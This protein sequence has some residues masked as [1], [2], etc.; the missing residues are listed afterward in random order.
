M[1]KS[2][3]AAQRE[4]IA[5]LLRKYPDHSHR[6]LARA[7]FKTWPEL[8]ISH[9][10]AYCAVR[11]FCGSRGNRS[12]KGRPLEK[13]RAESH[14]P[15]LPGSRAESWEP[16]QLDGAKRILILSDVHI[17]FHDT[18]ALKAALKFG[19]GFNPD[20]V[21]L[22]GD[23]A[24]FFSI[25]RYDSD[26][27]KRDLPGEI[28]AVRQF[29]SHVRARFPKARLVFKLGNHDERWLHFLWRKAPELLGLDVT[30][31]D[32]VIDAGKVGAEIVGDQRIIEVG[33]LSI[34]HGHEL[35]KGMTNPVNP[36]RGVFLRAIDIALIGHQHRTSEHTETTM[37]GRTITCWS[38]GCLCELHPEYAR[39]NRW[40]HGFA[41]VEVSR[42]QHFQVRNLRIRSGAIL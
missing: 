28:K 38:T 8:F 17:P 6:T 4:V 34:L 12:R 2:I 13:R 37:T 11:S 3:G 29:L 32:S 18:P 15:P 33:K 39:I 9:N 10:S 40:N 41:A 5:D 25:S 24:D 36:A 21:L 7:A 23:T 27:R 42:G 35:P 19:D 1:N 16:F 20:C 22:N 31:F 14:I 26:P 30:G